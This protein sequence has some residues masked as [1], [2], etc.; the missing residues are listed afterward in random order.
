MISASG[1]PL[2][3]LFVISATTVAGACATAPA[4]VAPSDIPAL[5]Q[6]V[7]TRPDDAQLRTRL[8]M[9]QFQAG[10]FEEARGS[11]RRA[12][13]GGDDSGAALLHLGMVEEELEDWSAARD[14]YTRY[15]EVGRSVPALDEVRARLTLVGRELVRAE[16]RQ[17]LARGTGPTEPL[18]PA[19]ASI[20]ILPLA[21]GSGQATMEPLA[22]ALADLMASDLQGVSGLSVADR[23][24]TQSLLDQMALTPAEYA[25]DVIGDR[26]GRVLGVEHVLQGTVALV[27]QELR[28]E[29]KV[30]APVSASPGDRSIVRDDDPGM[31]STGSMADPMDLQ[32][33]MVLRTLRDGL[34]IEPTAA[35]EDRI[36]TNRFQS[37]S[38]LIAYGR[39]LR[40]MDQGDFETA[41]AEFDRAASL[42]PDRSDR[43]EARREE[44]RALLRASATGTATL[45]G[46]AERTGETTGGRVLGPPSAPTTRDLSA[47]GIG[48][49]IP[50]GVGATKSAATQTNPSRGL[51]LTNVAEGVDPTPTVAMLG[52]SSA[53]ESRHPTTAR[54]QPTTRDPVQEILGTEVL[55]QVLQS[56][57]LITVRRPGGGR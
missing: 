23:T 14:A 45:A 31:V 29:A 50:V 46:L 49:E 7:T 28:V 44:A 30:H 5:H 18:V 22:Y 13:A 9:A 19:V 6:R 36:L 27:R 53:E 11:L 8:G 10:R 56:V 40:A 55:S 26:V 25:D 21:P 39:G 15:L 16:A 57:I 42:E 1:S 17:G 51:S 34:G 41:V 4:H 24:R 32:K 12:V 3:T 48:R 20:A 35:E 2:R 33:R 37:E 43:V 47:L 54:T 38:A 52:L